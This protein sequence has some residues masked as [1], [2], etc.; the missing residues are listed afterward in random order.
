M[1]VNVF[2][3]SYIIIPSIIGLSVIGWLFYRDFNS[4]LF[5]GLCCSVGTLFFILLAFVFIAGRDVGQ[6]YRF[7]ILSDRTLSLKRAL[8]V[9]ML[10]EF[11]SA[12]TP[13]VVGGSS[14]IVLFL[15]KEGINA[16]K[17]V[18]M[19]MAC[20]FLDELFLTLACPIVLLFLPLR[21]LFGSVA[22]FSSGVEIL[23]WVIY[24][25]ILLW[26]SLLYLALFHKPNWVKA[27][28][29]GLFSF[30]WLRKWEGA[31]DRLTDNLILSS[32]EMK[33]RPLSFWFK[34]FGLTCLS[35]ISRYLV[36]NALLLAFAI[37]GHAFLAFARQL[38]LWIVMIVSPTPGGSG[39]AEY[40]FRVYYADFFAVAAVALVVAFLWRIV[41]YY[42]YLIIGAII[43]P[44]WIGGLKTTRDSVD[45]L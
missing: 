32:R 6:V 36:V 18:A 13:S 15:N 17:S 43:L 26:T 12:V 38:V 45:Q 44:K 34:A 23:F 4:E 11:T 16:G 10:C 39:V 8:R 42:P 3:T 14:L 30:S 24:V 29:V 37:K 5:S 19:M 25:C 33:K 40:M 41:T 22:V 28:L 9:N 1:R 31:V 27:L 20:L 21:T 7:R 35:W 2:K